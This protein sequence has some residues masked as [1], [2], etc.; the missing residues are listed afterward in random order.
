MAR[1]KVGTSKKERLRTGILEYC[2]R[3]RKSSIR[4]TMLRLR[5]RKIIEMRSSTGNELA[6]W[7]GDCPSMS[8]GRFFSFN[9]IT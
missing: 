6:G 9:R 1:R 3:L 8:P 4:S 7:R 5:S 2:G